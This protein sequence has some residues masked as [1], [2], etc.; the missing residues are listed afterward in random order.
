MR[1]TADLDGAEVHRFLDNGE[2]CGDVQRHGVH[3]VQEWRRVPVCA[4][5]DATSHSTAPHNTAP[6]HST[7][8]HSTPQHTTMKQR[9]RGHPYHHTCTPSEQ[10]RVTTRDSTPSNA[11]STYHS[12]ARRLTHRARMLSFIGCSTPRIDT[13]GSSHTRRRGRRRA[14]TLSN[15]SPRWKAP[16]PT[17]TASHLRLHQLGVVIEVWQRLSHCG[18]ASFTGSAGKYVRQVTAQKLRLRLKDCAVLVAGR[19]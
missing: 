12:A 16:P 10:G 9:T 14:T 19:A 13:G 15:A 4:A 17:N 8:Q 7:P 6:H 3:T 2:V 18:R 1:H 11:H 5:H